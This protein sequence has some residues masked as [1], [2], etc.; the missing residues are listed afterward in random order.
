MEGNPMNS[1]PVAKIK[2]L[3]H[4]LGIDKRLEEKEVQ[5]PLAP[6][7]EDKSQATDILTPLRKI[8]GIVADATLH[9]RRNT[10]PE[11]DDIPKT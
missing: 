3:M 5:G 11:K 4:S 1:D 9:E 10:F 7:P 6:I 2:K 8:P